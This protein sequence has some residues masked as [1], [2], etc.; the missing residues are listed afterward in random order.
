MKV[1][2]F[3]GLVRDFVVMQKLGVRPQCAIFTSQQDILIFDFCEVL[4]SM[5]EPLNDPGGLQINKDGAII[6]R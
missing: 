4:V 2:R 3:D 5:G 6:R 1:E